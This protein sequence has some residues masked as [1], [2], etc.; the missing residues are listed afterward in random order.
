MS[1]GSGGNSWG[2]GT[3]CIPSTHKARDRLY[4]SS[5]CGHLGVDRIGSLGGIDANNHL[6]LAYAGSIYMGGRDGILAWTRKLAGKIRNARP[7][8]TCFHISYC[9][10]WIMDCLLPFRAVPDADMWSSVNVS[11]P[12]LGIPIPMILQAT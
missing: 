5:V 3:D 1:Y 7:M 8:V 9:V 11:H 6:W 12:G 2:L 4:D 10:S